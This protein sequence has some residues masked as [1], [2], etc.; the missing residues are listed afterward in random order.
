MLISVFGTPSPLTYWTLDA[1][2]RIVEE[3]Y[4]VYGFLHV[5]RLADLQSSYKA[6]DE[7]L[8]STILV[9]SEVPES[10]ISDLF[11]SQDVPILLVADDAADVA[12][13]LITA[14]QMD[15]ESAVRLTTQCMAT[16][17]ET[18]GRNAVLPL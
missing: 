15:R 12:S 11:L 16:L 10:R 13:Y 9:Y 18:A 5:S 3:L 14:R 4:G 1:V 17:S 2:K 6:L 8:R 7:G